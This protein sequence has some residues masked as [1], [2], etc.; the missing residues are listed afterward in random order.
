[1]KDDLEK[2]KA[3]GMVSE[4][5]TKHKHDPST[6]APKRKRISKKKAVPAEEEN[7]DDSSSDKDDPPL[8][9]EEVVATLSEDVNITTSTVL[10][11]L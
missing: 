5:R 1:L 2:K 10:P 7:R 11:D 9:K 6:A 4:G 8:T 3:E